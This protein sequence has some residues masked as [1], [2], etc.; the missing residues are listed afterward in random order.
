[1]NHI[2][3][4]RTMPARMAHGATRGRVRTGA[5][6]GVAYYA[7]SWPASAIGGHAKTEVRPCWVDVVPVGN[8]YRWRVTLS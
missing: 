6:S 1:M 3:A 7:S 8:A 4:L 5:R 2:I